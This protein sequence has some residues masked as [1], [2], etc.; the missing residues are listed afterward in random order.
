MAKLKVDNKKVSKKAWGYVD[1]SALGTKLADAYASGDATRGQIHEVYAAVPI[2][3]FG[4]DGDGNP[5]FSP[6]KAKLPHHE[7]DG[8]TIV[9]NQGG[10]EA[11]A[12]A[13]AGARS[14]PSLSGTALNMAKAHIRKHYKQTKTDAPDSL[15]ESIEYQS[16]REGLRQVGP[17]TP[18]K[19]LSSGTAAVWDG[20]EDRAHGRAPL[21]EMVK[22]SLEYVMADIAED[23]NEQF[24]VENPMNLGYSYNGYPSSGMAVSLEMSPCY[25]ADTFADHVVVRCSAD[26]DPD[27]YYLV[28]YTQQGDEYVFADRDAWEIVELTYQPQ[29]GP[30]GTE[31]ESGAMAER[32][33][34][35]SGGKQDGASARTAMLERAHGKRFE[36]VVGAT[37]ELGE[38]LSPSSGTGQ[39]VRRVK[40]KQAMTAGVVNENSRRYG[41]KVL[42]AAV[43]ELKNHLH[44]SAGQG[45]AIQLLGEAE[46]PN[47]KASRR[48]HLLET[49]VKWSDVGLHGDDVGLSGQIIETS[50]GKDILALMEVGVQPGISMRGYGDSEMITERGAQIED[51]TE[52]H[53]TGFDLVLEPSFANAA[54]FLESRHQHASPTGLHTTAPRLEAAGRLEEDVVPPEK[55]KEFILAHP[56]LFK[57][58]L[59]ED[60]KA[61][62]AEQLKGF[63]ETV[64]KAMSLPADADVW[65]ELAEAAQAKTEMAESKRQ[66]AI[67]EAITAQT[68]DLPYGKLGESFVKAVR[69]HK[70]ASADEVKPF[71]ESKRK[72]YDAI[73]A[74]ARLAGMGFAGAGV[75]VLGPVLERETGTPEYA[76][77][78]YEFQERIYERGEV[79]RHDLREAKSK[80]EILARKVLNLFD[81]KFREVYLAN[82]QRVG[83]LQEAKLLQEAETTSDLLLPYSV[84]RAVIAA[85]W[86]ELVAPN[87]FDFDTTD[88]APARIYYETYAEDTAVTQAIGAFEATTGSNPL[89]GQNYVSLANKRIIPGTLVLK[90]AAEGVTYTEGTDYVVD[91]GNG[92]I[93]ALAGGA[94]TA[95]QALHATA[96]Q[97]EGIRKGENV[98]IERAKTTLNFVLLNIAADRL[99]TQL[100]S[101]AIT[102]GRSQIGW[103]ATGR[104][105]NNLV[106][107]M[108]RK[109]ERDVFRLALASVLSVPS[110]SGG[111]WVAA[112][113][114]VDQ[115]VKWIGVSRVKVENRY[116]T[117]TGIGLSKANS[118]LLANWGAPQGT[119]FFYGDRADA[120]LMGNGY[121][122][123][124]KGIPVWATTEF[125]DQYVLVVNRELV[126]FRVL[127]PLTIKGPFPSYDTNGRL[128]AADQ[129]YAEEYD[130]MV[131]PI[132]N[133]GSYVKVA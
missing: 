46:H 115:F 64:R 72:E 37:V 81:E 111:T 107:E 8:S 97:F 104:T 48:P 106:K 22:G 74:S 113:D 73:V 95:G 118:D 9:L 59:S 3:A 89:G 103:D 84:A 122:G 43:K 123:R 49:V 13:L 1:K 51:V 55:I 15:K 34:E 78:S 53:I 88:Q 77:A 117:P 29:T 93:L 11:A 130:G 126:M 69:E 124:L 100:T 56:E 31:D 54:A 19:A 10:V 109:I 99:A 83:L 14:K 90:N 112:S 70:F 50:K 110:N 20:K 47:D 121:M 18:L 92:A 86:P 63:E 102:F 41:R 80:A 42:E 44:E 98:F 36:E 38:S 12:G 39:P 133:K 35:V 132:Q 75:K 30:Q 79:R 120:T 40:V 128:I 71:V 119:G 101:E 94:I 116:W 82:G 96:Y 66:K 131:S 58:M 33:S 91:Y 61:M 32:A 17:G 21:Q 45:R 68:K 60:I 23:F 4:K 105:I 6:S 28:T 26:L 25:I 24:A 57:G 129:Y 76:R 67:D 114:P 87:L 27:E 85:A 62:N 127:Q 108:M 125:T 7:L 2:D 52:L 16:L 5:K 65:K